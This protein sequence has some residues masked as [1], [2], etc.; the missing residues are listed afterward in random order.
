M[1]SKLH[2]KD[3]GSITEALIL[4]KLLQLGEKV[5]IPFG[6]NRR[7][8][9]LID[10]ENGSFIRIQCKTALFRT[11]CVQFSTCSHNKRIK[12]DD[13]KGDAD[14]FIV[15]CPPLNK[16]YKIKVDECNVGTMYLRIDPPKNNQKV[17]IRYA[18][19]FEF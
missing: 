4:S 10:K 1:S 3:V 11:G 19:D 12:G 17:G 14:L 2:T 6:D 8:D 7:Y 13:Y 5:L 9:L 16:Y 18:V 15:Y